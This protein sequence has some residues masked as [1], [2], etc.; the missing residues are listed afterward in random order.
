M[1]DH[2]GNAVV[3]ILDQSVTTS[4]NQ[5]SDEEE[6]SLQDTT[7]PRNT[8]LQKPSANLNPN[9]KEFKPGAFPQFS[10]LVPSPMMHPYPPFPVPPQDQSFNAKIPNNN[11]QEQL[12]ASMGHSFPLPAPPPQS[13]P[14][15]FP[16]ES[17]RYNPDINVTVS[18]IYNKQQQQNDQSGIKKQ[19]EGTDSKW[20]TE[21]KAS[22]RNYVPA[23]VLNQPPYGIPPF[24]M[25]PMRVPTLPS[26][27]TPGPMPYPYLPN[28]PVQSP[29]PAHGYPSMSQ[30]MPIPIPNIPP[31]MSHSPHPHF[32]PMLSPRMTPQ[33]PPASPS[34]GPPYTHG[35]APLRFV[36]PGARG[37]G[38]PEQLLSTPNVS[39]SPTNSN[40]NNTSVNSNPPI[41]L[42]NNTGKKQ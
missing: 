23:K 1:N 14:M 16:G 34:Y 21:N 6:Q 29:N 24:F 33:G 17:H 11:S 9:A 3:E 5:R 26:G 8:S 18:L 41:V 31:V 19:I 36:P 37:Y 15:H 38:Y 4:V 35:S 27:G 10:Y 25:P 7:S 12:L 13:P 30:P 39:H 40:V 42:M 2:A 32:P 22:W 20:S 28:S